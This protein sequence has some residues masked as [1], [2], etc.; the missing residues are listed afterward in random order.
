MLQTEQFGQGES[1]TLI[2][3]WG[4]Q[5]AVWHDWAQQQ[6]A[7]HFS[8]TLIELPGFGNTP[9]LE[10]ESGTELDAWLSA[11]VSVLPDK[12]HLLGWSLGGLLA[13]QIALRHPER[14]ESV[15]CLAS[16][17]RFT[18]N[19]DWQW[20]VSPKMMADFLK[21]VQADSLTTLKHFWKLQLQLQGGA[22]PRTEIRQFLT[23][24]QALKFPT[25]TGLVQGLTLLKQIDNRTAITELSQPLLWLLG[26]H[27][28]LVPLD[29]FE[30]FS[31]PVQ[32][33]IYVLQGAGHSP[34]YS[35]PDATAQAIIEFLQQEPA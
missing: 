20:A 19:D 3:G 30:H 5:N 8:V 28:P 34:F 17:P 18:Q 10:A 12:T 24:M 11:I 29:A 7:A 27:D 32:S 31:Q 9:A 15:I 6:L 33:Q 4:A 21:S 22:Q 26:E 13:Q 35:H 16:T 14:I 25:L 1:L 2:H 23:R